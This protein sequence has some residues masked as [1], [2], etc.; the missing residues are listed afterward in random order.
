MKA[1]WLTG[2]KGLTVNCKWRRTSVAL[3]CCCLGAIVAFLSSFHHS[4]VLVH[5]SSADSEWD[6]SSLLLPL[7]HSEPNT[8]LAKSHD[9]VCRHSSKRPSSVLLGSRND[10]ETFPVFYNLFLRDE[11]E[12]SRVN[13]LVVEQLSLLDPTKHNPVYIKTLGRKWNISEIATAVHQQSAQQ[14]RH[15][16]SPQ[17]QIQFLNH[18]KNGDEIMT[19][20]Q[21]WAYCR[22]HTH[23]SVVYLHSKGS[24]HA[25][26]D[27]EIFRQRLTKAAASDACYYRNPHLCNVCGMRFSPFP[28]PHHPGNMFV[29]DCNYV[30]HLMHPGKFVRAMRSFLYDKNMAE[31]HCFG[32]DRF[33]AE[34]WINSHPH[35]RPCDV[36]PSPLYRFG[37][38]DLNTTKNGLY[39]CDDLRI[40][41][42]FKSMWDYRVGNECLKGGRGRILQERIDEYKH[43]YG[44][45]A[46]TP[47]RSWWGWKLEGF[48]DAHNFSMHSQAS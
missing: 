8:V 10:D 47:P 22:N 5:T 12:R 31:K 9:E 7:N 26:P 2:R 32:V 25:N 37:Y 45:D 11:K 19:L 34:H 15:S 21:L 39:T 38:T 13:E 17:L 23:I 4:V 20:K 14:Q 35:V 40:A 1:G 48:V 6:L 36:E 27:N 44:P 43:L 24:F 41:P 42:R 29:A 18:K 30:Q 33:A 46:S 3:V 16:S 28:H